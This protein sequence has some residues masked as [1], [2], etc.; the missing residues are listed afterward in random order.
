MT[1]DILIQNGRL[2]DPARGIDQSAPVA[3]KGRRIIP[4]EE[5]MMAKTTIDASGCLVTPGLI[6][7][8]A[9]IYE[10]GTDSGA[11]P[12][13]AML[14]YGVTTV[15]D[16]GSSGV[17][18]YRSFLDRLALCRIKTK[19][20]LH[21][22][23]TG[24]VTHQYP[25]LLRPERWNMEKFQEAVELAGDK[26]LGFK[27]RVSRN[28]VG[29]AGLRPLEAALE[30]AEKFQKS[31]VVHVTD[32]PVLQSELVGRLRP[33]D[34]FCHL[35]HDRGNTIFENGGIP[36]ALWEARER[37]V[38]FDCCHGSANFSFPVAEKAV[39]AGFLPDIISTDLNTVTWCKPPLYN[40]LSVL[41][42]FLLLGVPLEKIL[43]CVTSTPAR[44]MGE[45]GELGTL[46]PGSCADIAI[47]RVAERPVEFVDTE[48]E[49]RNGRQ[50]VLP[51]AT[52][53][54]G[55]LVWRSQ[56]LCG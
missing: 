5:G 36:P 43:A 34:V 12:D 15:V 14:P 56:E 9:H 46:A 17:S 2:L 48:G 28:V 39:E 31:L 7:F 23:P 37:G 40:L 41:S 11:N 50:L 38:L 29:D 32:P 54:D 24:Q 13:L 44:L 27:L 42:K 20:F 18:T 26:L 22:S 4:W 55:V 3:V 33:G 35:Y 45:A 10:R 6:D 53:L 16:A 1:A 21:I 51:M 47:L 8:H 30:L 49:R 52:L 25:E 19:F